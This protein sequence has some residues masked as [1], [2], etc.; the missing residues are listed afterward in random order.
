VGFDSSRFPPRKTGVR[1]GFEAESEAIPQTHPAAPSPNEAAR[2]DTAFRAV[3]AA[4]VES[5]PELPAGFKQS[6]PGMI[7]GAIP[8]YTDLRNSKPRLRRAPMATTLSRG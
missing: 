8:N 5:W 2:D 3:V 1:G 4:I 7:R 6:L